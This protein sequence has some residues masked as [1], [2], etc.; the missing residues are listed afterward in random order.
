M[1]SSKKKKT[2]GRT[3]EKEEEEIIRS[4]FMMRMKKRRKGKQKKCKTPQSETN[5]GDIWE[6]ALSPSDSGAELA[7]R[8]CQEEQKEAVMRMQ[9]EVQIKESRW[10][11]A[12]PEKWKQPKGE[13]R[14]GMKKEA[15]LLRCTLLN[16][17]AWSTEKKYLT[18]YKGKC[19]IFFGIEH[20]L[21]TEDM[22]EQFIEKPRKAKEGWR[23]AADAARITDENAGTE[24]RKHTSGGVLY[25]K[26]KMQ[27]MM[28]LGRFQ[29]DLFCS[30]CRV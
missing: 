13:D 11:E 23:F 25:S 9:H 19:D 6:V 3:V 21:R 29:S 30:F 17:S 16:G 15:R 12:V 5:L 20:K 18:R 10:T 2:E 22:E 14:T 28:H 26:W 4:L 24:D 8:Q 7:E 27:K 1:A